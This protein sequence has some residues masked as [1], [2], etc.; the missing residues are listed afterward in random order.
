MNTNICAYGVISE[1]TVSEKK[2]SGEK[3]VWYASVHLTMEDVCV[4]MH[5]C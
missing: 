3:Y 1:Y 5:T 2:Q 4:F